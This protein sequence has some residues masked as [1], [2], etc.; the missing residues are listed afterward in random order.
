MKRVAFCTLGCKVNQYDSEA[1]LE[2]FMKNGYQAVD[3]TDPADVYVIN[4][5]IVTGA[6]E[7]KS[8]QMVRRA[9]MRNPQAEVVIAGCMAQ[10]D[11]EKLLPM[12]VRLVVGN[13]R[14]SE[15]VDLL[16][17]A[18]L[19]DVQIVAAEDVRRIAFEPLHI[20]GNMGHTRAVLKIQ[21]GCDRF[22]TYCIIP[23]VRGGIRS[24]EP[25]DIYT[26]AVRLGAAGYREVVLTGIH[27]TSYGRDLNGKSLLDAIRAAHAP[28]SIQRVRLG[29][30][31]PV[32]VTERFAKELATLPKVCPQFHLALQ[33]GSDTVLK[34]MRRR[35]DTAA[36][37]EASAI[38]RA[39]FPLCALTTD[40]LTGFPGE[41]EEEHAE[42]LAFCREI[43]F[44][45]MHVFPYSRRTG[46]EAAKM[47]G[48]LL[49]AV[50][51]QRAKELIALG[52]E[53]AA[54]YA[55]SLLN[56]RQDVLFEEERAGGAEGYTP[57]YMRVWAEG[58]RA[59]DILPVNLIRYENDLFTG[60]I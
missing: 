19:D 20:S 51:E 23:Y 52:E 31:E 6:G 48:Q 24:R 53:T 60:E 57:Q 46:T 30:L 11:A 40:V 38:L 50:K 36:F 16:H 39:V 21:E 35:Y 58:A 34:R 15:V 47:P 33:S 22:C 56:T 44:S 8:R 10:R 5:C 3:F 7:K 25:A 43:G 55:H 54:R 28:E 13:S 32:I 27:L 14:R 41:T 12:G 42:T 2:Q 17:Q 45:R 59:G 18:V 26:E 9:Q 4:T 29:S 37:R 49:K 1:M